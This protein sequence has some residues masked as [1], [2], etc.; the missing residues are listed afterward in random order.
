MSGETLI[1]NRLSFT[2]GLLIMESDIQDITLGELGKI[3]MEW[4][5]NQ[6]PVLNSIK[7]RFAKERPFQ[8]LRVGVCLHISTKTANL[9]TTIKAGGAD[10]IVCASNHLAPRMMLPQA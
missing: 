3:R 4:D 1:R 5:S 10:P 2:I 8:N 7:T 6:M 9:V